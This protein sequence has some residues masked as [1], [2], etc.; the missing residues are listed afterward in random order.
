MG[1]AHAWDLYTYRGRPKRV[2]GAH[3]SSSGAGR[4]S[5]RRQAS[6][7]GR[8]TQLAERRRVRRLRL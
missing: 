4:S 6:R 2:H 3:D 1:L 8:T 7:T 5:S